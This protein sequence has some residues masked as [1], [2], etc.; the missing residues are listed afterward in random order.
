MSTVAS[1]PRLRL[2]EFAALAAA[3]LWVALTFLHPGGVGNEPPPYERIADDTNK[4][5]FV[6]FSQLVLT[7]FVAVGVWM[8]LDGIHDRRNGRPRISCGLDG[9]L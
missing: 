1:S 5:M 9:V 7:P 3:L 4:W 6:H 2:L 8:L